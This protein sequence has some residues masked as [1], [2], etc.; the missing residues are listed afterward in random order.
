MGTYDPGN[1]GAGDVIV[2]FNTDRIDTAITTVPEGAEELL[3]GRFFGPD[4]TNDA[5]TSPHRALLDGFRLKADYA[6]AQYSWQINYFEGSGGTQD[7]VI[8]PAVILSGLQIT[9]TP[10]DLNGDA[11]VSELDRTALMSAIAAPPVSSYDLLNAAQHLY[12]LNADSAIDNLDL[13]TFNTHFL[14]PTGLAGDYNDNGFV[15]AADYSVWRDHLGAADESSLNGN[16]DGLNGVDAGDYTLWK[17]NFGAPGAGAGGLGAGA[18]P[19]PGT[20]V[21]CLL[22]VFGLVGF[23]RR[24]A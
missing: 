22:S 1:P 24:T 17:I 12:D 5:G 11:V 23:R 6:G 7:M 20:L 14:A 10:G 18:V 13:T 9:G 3:E 4:H 21:M 16:G 15:D 2:L 19:E 8:D